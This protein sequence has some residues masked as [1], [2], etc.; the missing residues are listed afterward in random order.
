MATEK[1]SA[2]GGEPGGEYGTRPLRI[3]PSDSVGKGASYSWQHRSEGRGKQH[4]SKC[5]AACHR[6]VLGRNDDLDRIAD[7]LTHDAKGLGDGC[8]GIL[9]GHQIGAAQSS[10]GGQ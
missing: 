3:W 1:H 10:L 2:E 9:V 8:Q 4:G 5:M 6:H 7:A